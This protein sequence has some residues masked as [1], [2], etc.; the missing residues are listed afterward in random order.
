ML[1]GVSDEREAEVLF[2]QTLMA[3]ALTAC[4]VIGG[5]A[6]N[7]TSLAFEFGS[8]AG[9][10]SLKSSPPEPQGRGRDWGGWRGDGQQQALAAQ[11]IGRALGEQGFRNV[12]NLQ[13]R[14]AIYQAQAQDSN[15]VPVGLVV[16]ARTGAILNV[17]RMR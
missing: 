17:Y 16:N 10:F 7:A 11:D 14:G 2:R 12:R 5:P 13:R 15:G 4:L 8:G 3:A 1:S 9:G 6:A